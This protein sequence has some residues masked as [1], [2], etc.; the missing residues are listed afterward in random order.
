V[1]ASPDGVCGFGAPKWHAY[2]C[3]LIRRTVKVSKT[4]VMERGLTCYIVTKLGFYDRMN[5]AT[6][7]AISQH[8]EQCTSLGDDGL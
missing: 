5:A 4:R 6:M 3:P 7:V 2:F 8:C 1:G